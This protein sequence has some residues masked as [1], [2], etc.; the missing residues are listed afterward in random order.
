M[1][2]TCAA[3]HVGAVTVN[4]TRHIID[5]APA[6]S[7]FQKFSMKIETALKKLLDS[8]Q[9]FAAFQK[10]AGGDVTKEQLQQVYDRLAQRNTRSFFA[11]AKRDEGLIECP[12][13][14]GWTLSR[15]S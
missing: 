1:G 7:D 6:K 10:D 5:G 13:R 14:D 15:S 11:H 8:P 2:V 9:A 12:D 4:G 3:C